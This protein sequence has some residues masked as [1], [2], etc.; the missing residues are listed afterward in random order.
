M[1][2]YSI[3]KSMKAFLIVLHAA[4]RKEV[5][6]KVLW[7]FPFIPRFRC[8]FQSSQTAKDLT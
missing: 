3:E 2:V 8:M 1:I 4:Y 6:A 7:Y 5:P